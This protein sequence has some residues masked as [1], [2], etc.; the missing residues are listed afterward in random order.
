MASNSVTERG[1]DSRVGPSADD[2]LAYELQIGHYY[3]RP[4]WMEEMARA[5]ELYRLATENGD[6]LKSRDCVPVRDWISRA[7][8]TAEEQWALGF[9]LSSTANAT[10]KA[11]SRS[12]GRS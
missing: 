12:A 4:S 5:R 3:S 10:A 9:G 11:P 6:L 8:I 1:T 2:L 7:G